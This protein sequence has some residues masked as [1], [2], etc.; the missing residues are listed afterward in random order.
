MKVDRNPVTAD[1]ISYKKTVPEVLDL[2]SVDNV[3]SEQ[4]K[5]LIKPNLVNASPYP[6]TTPA[7]CCA[8]IIEYVQSCSKAEI[9][10]GEGCGPLDKRL[11]YH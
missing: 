6:V 7:E 4:S 10:I 2:L 9:I 8:A 3:L 5:I 11:L 1:Y